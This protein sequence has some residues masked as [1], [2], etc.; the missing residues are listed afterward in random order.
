MKFA[1]LVEYK[2]RNIF[3]EKSYKQCGWETSPT[4]F[5]KKSKLS[6]SLG[7]QS[8]VLYKLLLLYVHVEDYQNLLKLRCWPLLLTS[9]A[10]WKKK[11][12]SGASI[13][14]WFSAWFFKK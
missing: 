13:T 2:I 5:P 9:N 8:E 1:P 7:Q 14:V 12:K 3:L 10:F 11:K 6:M 4:P